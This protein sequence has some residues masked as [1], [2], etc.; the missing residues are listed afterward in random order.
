MV[1]TSR[2]SFCCLFPDF[3]H[4]SQEPESAEN[5]VIRIHERGAAWRAS[6]R[7][8][9]LHP[10]PPALPPGGTD[11][12]GTT[13]GRQNLLFAGEAAEGGGSSVQPPASAHQATSAGLLPVSLF[14]PEKQTST[15]HTRNLGNNC[16]LFGGGGGNRTRN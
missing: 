11:G 14:T 15:A 12:G 16:L 6:R 4:Q 10:P 1:H 3:L 2:S 13:L 8:P 7:R 9:R 5:K